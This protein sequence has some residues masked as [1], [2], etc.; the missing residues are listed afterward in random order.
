MELKTKGKKGKKEMEREAS[1][2]KKRM[3]GQ[4]EKKEIIWKVEK[5][6]YDEWYRNLWNVEM[7]KNLT[8]CNVAKGETTDRMKES[9]EDQFRTCEKEIC[10][11]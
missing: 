10:N 6:E 11:E 3:L 7:M 2:E 9:N 1:C 5:D 8:L 4:E